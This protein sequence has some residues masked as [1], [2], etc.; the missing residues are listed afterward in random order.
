LVNYQTLS[1][2]LTGIGI[3]IAFIY[4]AQVLRN[5]SRARERELVY[6]KFQSISLEYVRTFNEV[7]L[8]RDWENA[9]EWEE[10]YGREN[11]LDAYSKWNYVTRHYQMAGILL[12]QGADPDIIFELYPDG[13]VINLWELF[14]PI[15]EH[16]KVK[17]KNRMRLDNLEYLYSEAKKRR[18]EIGK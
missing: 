12:K 1:I 16:M 10:K 9:E 13:A 6:Q 2:I 17:S 8:M 3:M 4:Y 15:M 7:M 11:N 5:T 14:E 18:P